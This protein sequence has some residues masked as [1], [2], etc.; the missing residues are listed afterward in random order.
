MLWMK[1]K[2]FQL[3]EQAV[4][5]KVVRSESTT[6]VK[7]IDDDS[8]MEAANDLHFSELADRRSYASLPFEC[9]SVGFN[10]LG[11]LADADVRSLGF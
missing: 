7:Y 3:I 1:C 6:V 4:R 10:L 8:T 5:S 2:R 9:P 11:L